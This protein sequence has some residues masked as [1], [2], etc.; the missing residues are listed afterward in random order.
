VSLREFYEREGLRVNRYYGTEKWSTRY[1]RQR[2]HHVIKL[3]SAHSHYGSFLDVGC[4][5][6]EYLAEAKKHYSFVIGLDVSYMYLC[7]ARLKLG[8]ETP[9]ILGSAEALP[10]RDRS[11]DNVLCSETLEHLA[12]PGAALEEL[13]RV[14]SNRL[15]MTTPNYGLA[16]VLARAIRVNLPALD[17]SVGHLHIFGISQVI[18][19]SERFSK[20]GWRLETAETL[21][22]LPPMLDTLIAF[23]RPLGALAT[24]IERVLHAVLSRQGNIALFVWKRA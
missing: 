2:F 10:F 23:R 24:A 14:A 18:L 15:V 9:L 12:R 11:F 19:A 20:I 6:G 3:L 22:V 4:A 21:H 8:R 13:F 16:R 1:H 17:R 7:R 5:A